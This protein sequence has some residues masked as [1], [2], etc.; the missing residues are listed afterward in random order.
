LA[1]LYVLDPV[2]RWAFSRIAST[3]EPGAVEE[4]KICADTVVN[5]LINKGD[6]LLVSQ[7][8]TISKKGVETLFADAGTAR[9]LANLKGVLSNLRI[10]ALNG[11]LRR[12][13]N[14]FWKEAGSS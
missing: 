1:L 5:G 12:R 8:V 7:N 4:A 11:Q 10:L 3:L 2:P 9:R 13:Y 6:A 14:E